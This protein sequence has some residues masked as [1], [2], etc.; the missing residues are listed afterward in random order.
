MPEQLLKAPAPERARPQPAAPPTEVPASPRKESPAAPPVF[1]GDRL[2][3]YVW[4]TSAAF[5]A[6]VLLVST[7]ASLL[8]R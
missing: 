3:V 7:L 1:W 6:A 2:T 5:L 8:G 4:M